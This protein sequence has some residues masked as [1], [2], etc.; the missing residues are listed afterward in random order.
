MTKKQAHIILYELWYNGYLDSNFTEPHTEYDWA[1]DLLIN[2]PNKYSYE[3]ERGWEEDYSVKK[4]SRI[5]IK[6]AKEIQSD[7]YQGCY[8]LFNNE[9]LVYVGVSNCIYSRL[10]EHTRENIKEWNTVKFF[11]EHDRDK[12]LEKE[13]YFIQKYKPKYNIAGTKKH[14]KK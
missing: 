12:A 3:Y 7:L 6:K 10:R 8:L 5:D 13:N 1:V 11:E 2:P 14:T 9:K 4:I